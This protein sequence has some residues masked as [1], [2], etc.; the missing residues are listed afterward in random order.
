MPGQTFVDIID[1]IAAR[2]LP[3]VPTTVVGYSLGA[4]VALAL[5]MRF[6]ERVKRLVLVGVAYGIQNTHDRLARQRAD[7][8][9]A[10]ALERDGVRT[11][12]D[13]WEALPL[14]A[15][16]RSLSDKQMVSQRSWRTA[17]TSEGLAWSLRCLG[18]G[19][20]PAYRDAFARS[21]VPVDVVTGALDEKFTTIGGELVRLRT[22]VQHTVVS[23]VGH[24]VVLEAPEVIARIVA[25]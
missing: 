19:A 18:L 3:E 8:S 6:P 15:S 20:Q 7:E 22:N 13:S 14:F 25:Q 24:N 5:A 16:Q 21:T 10:Q 12:V 4:R 9:L 1:A 17:H 23:G 11:F 2:D